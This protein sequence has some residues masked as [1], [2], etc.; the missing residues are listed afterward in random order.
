VRYDGAARRDGYIV[1]TVASY[2]EFVPICPEVESGMGVPRPPVQLMG[3]PAHPRMLGVL[4]QR[5]DFTAGMQLF[6]ATVAPRIKHISGYIFKSRSPSC[7]VWDTPIIA[8]DGPVR[9]YGAGLFARAVVGHRPHLP[10]QDERTLYTRQVRDQFFEQVFSYRRWQQHVA[11]APTLAALREFHVAHK[12]SLL[13]HDAE[14][15]RAL[16]R[17]LATATLSPALVACYAAQFFT[18]LRIPATRA[19]HVNVLQYLVGY[20]KKS[21][22]LDERRD[23]RELIASYDGGATELDTVLHVVR[24]LTANYPNAYLRKQYYLYPEEDEALLRFSAA[25]S[26]SSASGF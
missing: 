23:L 19:S 21:A 26:H 15:Y 7:G 17:R 4:D 8:A 2:V 22:T 13:A 5:A 11:P 20:F 25:P 9:A 14:S 24:A 1:D 10:V 18:A 12:Y 3:D 6:G 16:G